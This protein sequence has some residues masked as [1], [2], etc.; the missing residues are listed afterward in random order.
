[1]ETTHHTSHLNTNLVHIILLFYHNFVFRDDVICALEMFPLEMRFYK[2]VW[3][4]FV[5]ANPD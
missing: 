2:T 5:R 4:V 1:M 3:A